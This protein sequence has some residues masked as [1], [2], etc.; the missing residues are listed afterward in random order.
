MDK[1]KKMMAIVLVVGVL[2]ALCGCKMI[3]EE[4]V[5]LKDL[6]FSVLSEEVIPEELKAIID[7]RKWE[8]FQLTYSDASYLYIVIGYGQQSTGGYSIAVNDLYLTEEAIYVNTT[9]LGPK[10]DNPK[11]QVPSSP[12]IVLKTDFIDKPVVFE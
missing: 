2:L 9:L 3:N 11:N 6:G 7:E 4:R 5:K 1:R 12:F 8:E 10:E